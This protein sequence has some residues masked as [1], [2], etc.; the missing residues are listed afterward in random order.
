MESCTS[1]KSDK[2]KAKVNEHLDAF[3]C[4]GYRTLAFSLKQWAMNEFKNW[5]GEVEKTDALNPEAAEERL[6]ELYKVLES[7]LDL[8]GASALEDML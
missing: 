4:Q 7:D 8:I 6:K 3:S 2:Y 1:Q 5:K